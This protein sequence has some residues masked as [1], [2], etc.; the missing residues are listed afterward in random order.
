MKRLPYFL[1]ALFLLFAIQACAPDKPTKTETK[2]K[3]TPV[4]KLLKPKNGLTVSEKQFPIEIGIA[5][6]N[7]AKVDSVVAF[8]NDKRLLDLS[9]NEKNMVDVEQLP[10]GKQQVLITAYKSDGK[11]ENK[12]ANLNILSD[13]V[14]EIYGFD[15][16]NEY[17]HNT[18]SYTQGL[19]FHK[20]DLYESTG[21]RGESKLLKIDLETGDFLQ[22]EELD[23]SLFGEG[24][25]LF[26]DELFQITWT[27]GTG[28]VYDRETFK[29][30]KTFS[31]SG[32][33]WGLTH[34]GTHL[35]MSNGSNE[36]TFLDPQNLRPIRSIK[37]M[38]NRG[39]V[40]QLNELEY[41]NGEIW[42]NYY[43]MDVFKVVRIDPKNGKVLGYVNFTGILDPSDRFPGIDVF[44]G[45][46]YDPDTDRLFVT[47]KYWPKLYEVR[48][49]PF[50]LD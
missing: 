49:M 4:F 35:L 10:V 19:V 5:E 21:Q 29:L 13:I 31:Y 2:P 50:K 42:A 26:N 12:V 32:Q 24:L 14:P 18:G 44:N 8:M 30:K 46:A 33:G 37:V 45:M 28:F 43:A 34:D 39:A 9:I 36:I 6:E 38:D 40:D 17:P 48:T 22:A 3:K 20:G 47:G 1:F 16:V 25:T 7:L 41:I 15:I 27:S 23:A 11:V